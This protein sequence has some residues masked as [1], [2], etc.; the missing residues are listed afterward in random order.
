MPRSRGGRTEWENIVSCCNFCN[1][2]KADR[3]PREAGLQLKTKPVRPSWV[4]SFNISLRDV[5]SIP[6]EWREYWIV[7]LE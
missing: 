5:R 1:A 2:K 7:E 6:D 4:P 3:T